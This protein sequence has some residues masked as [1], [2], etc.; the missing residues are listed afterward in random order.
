M[1]KEINYV[2]GFEGKSG[3]LLLFM[4]YGIFLGIKVVL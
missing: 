1:N 3:N 4:V 2:L